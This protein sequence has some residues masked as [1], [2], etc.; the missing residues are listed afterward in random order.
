[1]TLSSDAWAVR[2]LNTH[3]FETIWNGAPGE[4][5][6]NIA[7]T[8]IGQRYALGTV[9]L[10]AKA[11]ALPDN[12]PFMAFAVPYRLFSNSQ[13]FRAGIWIASDQILAAVQTL[14]S[15]YTENGIT[16]PR[17][18]IYLYRD[19]FSQ[20][21]LVAIRYSACAALF[22]SGVPPLY[23]TAYRNPI[24]TVP[25]QSWS[26]QLPTPITTQ[27]IS[28][29]QAQLGTCLTQ[30]AAG[31][32]VTVNGY[33]IDPAGTL[34]TWKAGDLIDIL[35]DPSVIAAYDAEIMT[36]NSGYM[37]TKY[38]GE[39]DILHCPKASNPN[40][41]IL[42]HE[43]SY[44]SVWDKAARRGMRVPRLASHCIEQLT[45]A[46]WSIDRTVV[47]A[48]KTFLA[49]TEVIARVRI[50][51][52]AMPHVLQPNSAWLLSLYECSD[53]E[54][55]L[56]MLGNIDAAAVF[57]LAESL[58]QNPY[59]SLMFQT[60][61]GDGTDTS[62]LS[63][64]RAALGYH[65]MVAVLGGTTQT[66]LKAA[67]TIILTKPFYLYLQ[68]CSAMVF[69]DGRKIDSDLVT[70][71]DLP[72]GRLAISIASSL[73]ITQPSTFDVTVV[74]NALFTASTVTNAA[75]GT[76]ATTKS[77]YVSVYEYVTFAT[78]IVGWDGTS[79]AGGYVELA[80]GTTTYQV[81]ANAD[82]TGYDVTLFPLQAGKTLLVIDDIYV[83]TTRLNID[84]I[85]TTPGPL[86]FPLQ[87]VDIEENVIPLLNT[88]TVE[89]YINGLRLA[90]GLDY[91]L[92]P[93]T[94]SATG[95]IARI[96]VVIANQSFFDPEQSNNRVE[97]IAH[98]GVATSRDVSYVLGQTIRH[99]VTPSFWHPSLSRLFVEGQWLTSAVWH[100]DWITVTGQPEGG[101]GFWDTTMHRR[102]YELM[103]SYSPTT[104]Y[105]NL[106][107]VEK[108]LNH[109]IPPPPATVVLDSQHHVYSPYLAAIIAD[110]IAGTL[111]LVDDP[112]PRQ[113]LKQ[114]N[115]YAALKAVDPSLATY[116]GP[117]NTDYVAISA[118]YANYTI[119]SP[120]TLALVQRLISY[121]LTPS[122]TLG[123]TLL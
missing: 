36:L 30:N 72:N 31:T 1:M 91:N 70:L 104:D 21:A 65:D 64:Y 22:P 40:T 66:A 8:P 83:A 39:R 99:Q 3:S 87:G 7:L 62:V 32:I 38:N 63:V 58:E 102:L 105:T 26:F 92:M 109:I 107:I 119:V 9:V 69:A 33:D 71:Q 78:P 2:R 18:A 34:P 42:T 12:T 17:N 115:K 19:R 82:N 23:I 86:I 68:S 6:V 35:L 43:A 122:V 59:I 106:A 95:G 4:Y 100:T 11:Y 45:H 89:I 20:T 117:I 48:L 96:D 108:T 79:L 14:L 74:E 56:H 57:W 10:G 111:I 27:A 73:P 49:V 81:F 118:N 67:Q 121:V 50:R 55:L 77:P 13:L 51:R 25:I 29:M 114:F 120:E 98:S 123:E 5:T 75:A 15:V 52:P 110:V 88:G 53:A 54:I 76:I 94:D 47:Q 85:L 41:W 116:A 103:K 84:S 61:V 24:I 90:P 101:V 93:W 112:D 80:P 16:V 97:I 60:P 37:S 28:A 46:D 113:F 44:V